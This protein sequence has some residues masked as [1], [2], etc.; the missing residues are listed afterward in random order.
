MGRR[1]PAGL[2]LAVL[3]S[4]A[5]A[6]PA[7]AAP[8][9]LAGAASVDIAVPEGTPLAGYGGYPRRAWIPDLMGRQPHAFW[10]RPSRG[11]HDPIKARALALDDGRASLVWVAVDLVGADPSLVGELRARLARA[12]LAYSALILA[13]SHTHSGP[14]AYA[15]SALFAFV[16][17]DR[18]SPDVRARILDALE[19]AVREA[20][21]RRAPARVGVG[22][23]EVSEIARSRVQGPLD[24]T[25]GVL[26]VVA[27]VD[28]RPIALLWNYAIHGT[29]LGRRN[30]LVSGDLMAEASARIERRLGAPALFV[31]GAVGDVSPA[32]RG[33]SGVRDIGARLARE[34]LA[35]WDRITPAD[36]TPLAVAAGTAALPAP[37]LSLRNCLGRWV[38]G[39][40]RV[41]LGA[42]LPRTAE[43]LAVRIGRSG[44]VSVPG[45][46][47]TRLGR[48][49]KA[50][51]AGRFEHVFVAGVSNDYLGYFM[52]REA[53]D[54]PSYVACA[55]LYGERGGELLRDAAIA[56]LARLGSAGAR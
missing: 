45:E 44:W 53:Y 8:V 19:R 15:E 34:A 33:W 9:L 41:G 35:V 39:W 48:D 16:A 55:S 36:E 7:A 17:V 43:L 1:R 21:A 52:G 56:V 25:L 20:H 54:R 24:P 30:A 14:G 49:V 23:G 46:L 2:A 47:E 38:P 40:L 26:K 42:A 10:F 22:A 18:P 11:V 4:L 13:A 31:N 37:A 51:G 32:G 50:S 5:L 3:A 28:G 27:A 12:G 29:A 6:A